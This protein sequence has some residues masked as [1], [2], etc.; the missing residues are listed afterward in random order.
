[1][2]HPETGFEH[3]HRHTDNSLLD[4]IGTVKEYCERMKEINQQ[5]LCVT[6]HG[7]MGAIPDQI[8]YCEQNGLF[9]LFGCELYINPMQPEVKIRAESAEFRKNLP[10]DQQKKFDVCPHLVAIAAT[11]EGYSNLVRMS[12]W[13]WQHGFYRKPRINYDVLRKYKEGIVFTTACA[14]SQIARAFFE[15]GDD[16]AFQ[17]LEDLIEI[18]G[19]DNL[20]LEINMLDFE[21]QKP[22]DQLMIKC[23]E[24]YGLDLVL[25]QDCHYA[26]KEHSHL[27]R[28]TLMS[29]TGR[30]IAEIKAMIASGEA[31]DIF[32]LQDQNLWCKSEQE[33][34]EKWE[35]SYKDV[36]DYE[37]FKIAKENSV[38]IAE[39]CKGVM[40]DREVKLPQIA[41]CDAILWEQTKLGFS[42]R[43][44]PD[45]PKYWERIQEEYDLICA[46]GFSSYFLIEKEMLDVIR[47]EGPKLL[48][49]GDGSECVGP[50]RGS[51]CGSLVAYCLRLH[52]VEPIIHDLRFSRFL[53]P[54]RGGKQMRVRHTIK[55]MSKE[56]V[57]AK[58]VA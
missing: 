15:S 35:L 2:N 12:S 14:A 11:N 27:Q 5:Y 37:L 23:H 51:V 50:G 52:D 53:S 56:L 39:R 26:K 44:C 29:Q 28:C 57:L 31:G 47:A 16:A 1:M 6:D 54:A 24:R 38:K 20:K 32:E 34:N 36:I 46:K 18:I 49:F 19:K 33:L 4:G 17:Q 13:A 42:A 25:T 22:Y 8:K 45:T 9:P 30:T 43:H 10:E 21:P 48:G 55:P 3:L 40:L 58:R 41:D 7:V